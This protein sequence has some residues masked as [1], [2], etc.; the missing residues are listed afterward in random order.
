MSNNNN[1]NPT[2]L[3][4]QQQ[5]TGYLNSQATGYNQVGYQQTGLANQMTGYQQPQQQQYLNPQATGY[6]NQGYEPQQQQYVPPPV[7]SI[8]SKYANAPQAPVV[9]TGLKIPDGMCCL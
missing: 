4:Q 5:P 2:Y 9:N 1:F 7:P 3:Q 6:V 8:P